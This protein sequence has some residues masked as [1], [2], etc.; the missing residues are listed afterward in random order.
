MFVRKS[1]PTIVNII[2]QTQTHVNILVIVTQNKL[3]I[4]N[5]HI[6][7]NITKLRTLAKI[8]ILCKISFF[9]YFVFMNLLRILFIQINEISPNKT[10]SIAYIIFNDIIYKLWL[11]YRS[12]IFFLNKKINIFDNL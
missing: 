3:S 11:N 1:L 5:K 4:S 12:I 7:D 8:I 9:Q 6:N 10:I 2:P